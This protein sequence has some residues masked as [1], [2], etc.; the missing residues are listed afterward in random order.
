MTLRYT[1]QSLL[2]CAREEDNVNF[3]GTGDIYTLNNLPDIDYGV[4]YITQ[5][6]TLQYEN[7]TVFSFTLFYVDRLINENDDLN[8]LKI[9][10]D[11]IQHLTNILNRFNYTED[12]A[13]SYPLQ[14]T[15]FAQRFADDCAGVFCS[16]Q[17]T[18]DNLGICEY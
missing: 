4:F 10:S 6:N 5:N 11:G 1:I 14:F 17:I 8:R 13:L 15:S 3:V 18:A 7:Y 16:V 2:E 12:I 9:Q